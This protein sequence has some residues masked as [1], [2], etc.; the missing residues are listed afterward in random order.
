MHLDIL[1]PDKKAYSGEV[2]SVNLPGSAGYFE[3]HTNHAPIISTLEKGSI[4]I[5][6]DNREEII[7]VD[8]GIVEVLN[9]NITVLAEAILS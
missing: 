2:T 1:T 3:V 7:I 5:K 8:G 9:N 4:K 6:S